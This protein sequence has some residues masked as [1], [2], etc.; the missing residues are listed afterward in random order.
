MKLGAVLVVVA[1]AVPPATAQQPPATPGTLTL[2]GV[3]VT[4]N[5]VPLAR[6][7][8]TI[9]NVPG[10]EPPTFTDDRGEFATPLPDTESMRL[11]FTKARYAAA[12]ID[13]RRGDVNRRDAPVLRVRLSLGGAISGHVR[14]QFGNPVMPA[15]ITAQRMGSG[16]AAGASVL[17]ATT[18]DLG[19]FR[20]GGLVA[21]AYVI[22]LSRVQSGAEANIPEPSAEQTVNVGLGAE[23]S[24]IDLTIEMPS[25][26][27][28]YPRGLRNQPGPDATASLRGRVLTAQG[29]PIAG[30]LVQARGP[31][32]L[33]QAVESDARGRYVIDFVAPGE[34]SIEAIKRGFMPV[35]TGRGQSAVEVLLRDRAPEN[36]II[37]VRSGQTVDSVDVTL[38]RG[39]SIAGTI[40]DE[41]GEPMQGV[42]VSALVLRAMGGRTRALPVASIP[43]GSAQTDDRGRYRLFGLQPGTYVVQATAGGLLSAASGYVPLFYSGTA[44]IDLATSKKLAADESAAAVDFTLLPASSRRVRGRVVDPEGKPGNVGLTLAVRERSGSI[45]TEPVRTRTSADGTFTFNGVAPGEYVVHASAIGR[46]GP[47]ASVAVASQFAEAFVTVA[48]DDPPRLQLKLS[49]G[50]TLKGRV[51]YEGIAAPPPPYSGV[52][53]M[54][55]PA[56]F[57]RDPLAGSMGFALLS[58]NTFEYRGVFGRN[59]LVGQPR[60]PDWYVKSITYRNQDLTDVAVDFGVTET[61]QDIEVVVSGLGAALIGRATDDRAAPV[62][63][64]TVAVFPTDRSKWTLRSRWLKARRSAQDGTFRLTGLVPGDYWIVAVDRLEGSDVAGELQ[65][66]DILDALSSRA[67]RITLGEGQS[68]D[69]TLRLIRR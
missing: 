33:T 46:A 23:V 3:V 50:A 34:Y 58:D 20:F 22:R 36:R 49:L 21:G 66:P 39:A 6:V 55:L 60:N 43:G 68:R 38:A 28:R 57:D 40:V 56:D 26:L 65:S 52:G 27:A 14:D 2:R 15:T 48:G 32:G 67:A 62:R 19:E 47:S 13:L 64:Y 31:G 18:N 4:D 59:F 42:S 69:L 44:A 35:D 61:F 10:A 12:T 25:E 17:T 29:A 51:V 5:D 8:V 30:A 53:L 24:G 54:A 37:P 45:H 11:T 63:D 1:L 9:V 41:F 7:R 16:V